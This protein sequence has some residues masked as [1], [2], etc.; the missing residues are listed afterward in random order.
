[1]E[2]EQELNQLEEVLAGRELQQNIAALQAKSAASRQ[3]VELEQELNQLEEV[4]ARR[5]LQQDIAALQAESAASRR[6]MEL[7]QELNQLEEL[8]A[9]RELQ[10]D[11]AMLQC[12]WLEVHSVEREHN[13]ISTDILE[14][15]RS[16]QNQPIAAK[17][18]ETRT[19]C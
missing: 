13:S 1:M 19:N 18:R 15:T 2:Q 12:D 14:G 4:L 9:Q 5:E 6:D 7:E 10:Q 11:I 8:L 16:A 3:E 17:H